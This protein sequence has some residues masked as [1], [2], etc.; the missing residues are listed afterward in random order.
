MESTPSFTVVLCTRDR[1]TA[2]GAALESI[3]R[4][5]YPHRDF[6]LVL[7]DNGSRDATAEVASRFARRAPFAVRCVLEPEPGLSAA[8]NRGIR[9]ARG[10]FLFFTDDDQLVDPNVLTE[11]RRVAEQLGARVVQGKIEL[12]F[13]G[14]RPGW[15]SGPL[16]HMLGETADAPE[17]PVACDLYGGNMVLC[18]ALFDHMPAFR[19]DLGKGAAGW[20]EDVELSRRLR[21]RGERIVYAPRARVFHV[22]GAERTT[23]GYFRRA[24]LQK[25]YSDGLMS[26]PR[27]ALAARTLGSAAARGVLA[28][29]ARAF[30]GSERALPSETRALNRL[31]RLAGLARRSW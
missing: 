22:I 14:G 5:A 16:G 7:V 17:G 29:G 6:E 31:G 15:L 20:A 24:A 26:E 4:V 25:G 27:L 21:A 12:C 11:H 23:P 19:H 30:R 18:R 13:P 3:A 2:L 8:R 10:R 9:E 28:V 1:A